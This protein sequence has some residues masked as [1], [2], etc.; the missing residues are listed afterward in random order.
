ME[1]DAWF[2]REPLLGAVSTPNIT[3]SGSASSSSHTKFVPGEM[4]V[5]I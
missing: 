3:L 2:V 5:K 1:Q 4:T